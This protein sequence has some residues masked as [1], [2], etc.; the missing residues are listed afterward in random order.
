MVYVINF[1]T[2]F[3]VFKE[4][5]GHDPPVNGTGSSVKIKKFKNPTTGCFPLWVCQLGWKLNKNGNRP[6]YTTH[7]SPFRTGSLWRA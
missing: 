1:Y 4:L 3:P 7:V 2:V 5:N 6:Q